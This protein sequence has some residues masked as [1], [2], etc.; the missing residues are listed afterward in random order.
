MAYARLTSKSIIRHVCDSIITIDDDK[1][2]FS[3]KSIF[4]ICAIF[5]FCFS[6]WFILTIDR[7]WL[8]VIHRMQRCNRIYFQCQ[9]IESHLFL[10]ERRKEK[11]TEEEE[12]ED[13]ERYWPLCCCYS[14]QFSLAHTEHFLESVIVVLLYIYAFRCYLSLVI[15]FMSSFVWSVMLERPAF[16]DHNICRHTRDPNDN[17][18]RLSVSARPH[19]TERYTFCLPISYQSTENKK[20]YMYSVQ[21]PNHY[22]SRSTKKIGNFLLL[23]KLRS[24]S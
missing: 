16:T 17:V 22:E 19:H 13:K 14:L 5:H 20:P 24:E 15:I 10:D 7:W 18:R 8:F 2:W 12:Q 21:R 9:N 3:L 23:L 1:L 4:F 11:R 6:L